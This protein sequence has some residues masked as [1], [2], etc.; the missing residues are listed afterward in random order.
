MIRLEVNIYQDSSIQIFHSLC[1]R[2]FKASDDVR[3]HLLC[4]VQITTTSN[5]RCQLWKMTPIETWWKVTQQL[6]KTKEVIV[7]LHIDDCEGNNNNLWNK[8]WHKRCIISTKFIFNYVAEWETNNCRLSHERKW[9]DEETILKAKLLCNY[10][11]HYKRKNVDFRNK[12]HQR[13][14]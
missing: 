7:R 12:T 2:D 9:Y 6:N 8:S 13:H 4:L 1:I 10:I 11:I 14:K 5:H 3:L